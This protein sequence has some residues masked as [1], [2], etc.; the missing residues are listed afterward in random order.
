MN[1][2]C[3]LLRHEPMRD[4]ALLDLDQMR[5]RGHCKRCGAAMERDPRSP[6]RVVSGDEADEWIDSATREGRS[7]LRRMAAGRRGGVRA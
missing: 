2:L 1:I 7:E 3:R 4:K 5:Q 6:W